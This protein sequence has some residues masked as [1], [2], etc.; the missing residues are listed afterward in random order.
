MAGIPNE[1]K[2]GRLT[3]SCEMKIVEEFIYFL[4]KFIADTT[5]VLNKKSRLGTLLLS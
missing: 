5:N 1:R 4:K 3:I 2:R